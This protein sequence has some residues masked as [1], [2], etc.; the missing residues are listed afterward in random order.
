MSDRH[1]T[2]L[3]LDERIQIQKGIENGKPFNA[4]ASEIG[5]DRSTVSRE[6]KRNRKRIIGA[7]R[8]EN[9]PCMHMLRR[10]CSISHS[11]GKPCMKRTC[12]GCPSIC[13]QS[14]PGYSLAV[15]E[16]LLKPPYVCNACR[17][18]P[19]VSSVEATVLPALSE[20]MTPMAAMT[21]CVTFRRTTRMPMTAGGRGIA[22][23]MRLTA[24]TRGRS[25]AA[26][27]RRMSICI[28]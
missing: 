13:N 20:T 27:T 28:R 23:I 6:V 10:D 8:Q 5:K 2:Q 11:C 3:S 26:G 17:R 7:S 4:I 15:C 22:S 14:C 24:A 25:S 16:L 21:G 12:K 9:Q 1:H 18:S 19:A